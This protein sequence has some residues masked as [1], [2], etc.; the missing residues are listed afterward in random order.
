MTI[1]FGRAAASLLAGWLLACSSNGADGSRPVGAPAIAEPSG[2]SEVP[3]DAA[4]T[5]RADARSITLDGRDA[6]ARGNGFVDAGS[7]RVTTDAGMRADAEACARNAPR[8]VT[9][10]ID[11]AFGPGQ[12]TGQDEFPTPVLG[13]PRGAGCCQGSFDVVSL[14]NG[15]FIVVEFGS[16]AIVDGPGP[17]FIVFENAFWSGGDEENPFAELGTVSVSDD[18]IEWFEFPCTAVEA[19]FGSCAGHQPVFANV[20]END[21]DPLDPSVAGGDPFDL[22]DIGVTRARYVRIDDRADL[23]GFNGSFD[24]DAV[25]IVNADCP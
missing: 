1:A 20:E 13:P 17:D 24:L 8:F 23:D 7:A 25:G 22:A 4:V 18:G 15:G 10:V 16:N 14:G 12:S 3:A 6:R 19:P 5:S 11:H 9:G 21:I 2:A